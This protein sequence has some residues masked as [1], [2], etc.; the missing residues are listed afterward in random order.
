[1][2][3]AFVFFVSSHF[4]TASPALTLDLRAVFVQMIGIRVNFFENLS[5][6]TNQRVASFKVNI[7]ILEFESLTTAQA[8]KANF[9]KC[10]HRDSVDFGRFEFGS[11]CWTVLTFI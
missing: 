8:F 6:V 3:V 7:G 10:V 4:S 11:A 5:T 2:V 9:I 1:M